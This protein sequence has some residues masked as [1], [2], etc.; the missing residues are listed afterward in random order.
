MMGELMSLVRLNMKAL[1]ARPM[2]AIVASFGVACVVAVLLGVFAIADAFIKLMDSEVD[3]DTILVM[4]GGADAESRSILPRDVVNRVMTAHAIREVDGARVVSAEVTHL[5]SI[6]EIGRGQLVNVTVRG[7]SASAFA[8]RSAV[9]VYAGRNFRS[10]SHELIIGKSA[11]RQF[12]GLN[13]GSSV[14]IASAEWVVVGLFESAGGASESEIW[15]DLESLQSG[16][17][18]LEGVQ[19]VRLKLSEGESISSLSQ[20]LNSVLPVEVTVQSERDFMRQSADGFLDTLTWLSLPVLALMTFGAAFAA[21]STMYGAVSTRSKEIGTLRAIGFKAP[22]ISLA[23]LVESLFVAVIGAAMGALG[24]YLT[25]DGQQASTNFLSNSQYAFQFDISGSA[26]WRAM[27]G[28]VVIG[29]VGGLLPA[30]RAGTI[31]IVDA[32][33]DR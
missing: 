24:V 1:M 31:E 7:V 16:F 19:S 14:V 2:S 22:P 28:A 12:E 13:V 18:L 11:H 21:L 25:L 8:V 4:S 27:I 10:G 20:E 32:L 17:Q 6:P 30:I 26:I 33:R 5:T 9:K 15:A 29:L 23:F 3:A